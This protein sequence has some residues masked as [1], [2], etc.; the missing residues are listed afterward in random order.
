M[1]LSHQRNAQ[2]AR[3]GEFARQDLELA[4]K[5]EPGECS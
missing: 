3:V 1:R 4:S 2:K 5:G